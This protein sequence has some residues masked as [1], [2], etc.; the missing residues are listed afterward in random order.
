NVDASHFS[1]GGYRGHSRARRDNGYA[2]L[3]LDTQGG[4][5]LTL[6]ANA[7]RLPEA[8]D[9][10]GLTYAQYLA[11]PR[12]AAPSALTFNTRK[13]VRQTQGGAVFE[14]PIGDRQQVRV[15]AYYGQR[16]ITQFLSVPV[17]AQAS[18][19]SSGGVIDLGTKYGGVDARWIW[20][21]ELAGRALQ[22]TAGV[23]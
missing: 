15:L 6:L 8:Q 22:F 20:N 17:F 12:Q 14:Q 11:D 2:K 5:R 18:P 19:L 21:G 10:Q 1:T 7:V 16:D 9:P 23:S 3:T 4:G 13:S